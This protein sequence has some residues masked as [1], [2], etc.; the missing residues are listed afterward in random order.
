MRDPRLEEGLEVY[1]GYA[2][3]DFKVNHR[4]LLER[5]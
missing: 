5:S 1:S 2:G 4:P 3:M